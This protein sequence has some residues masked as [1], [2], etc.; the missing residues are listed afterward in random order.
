MPNPTTSRENKLAFEVVLAIFSYDEKKRD[1]KFATIE[2]EIGEH[3][4]P[5]R[6]VFND[7]GCYKTVDELI[8]EHIELDAINDKFNLKL[9]ACLDEPHR[10]PGNATHTASLIF[11]LDI[12]DQVNNH[13]LTWI[14]Y[15]KFFDMLENSEFGKDHDK[16]LEIAINHA[17]KKNR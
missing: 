12:S 7:V 3:E 14:E 15:D 13:E 5:S 8:Y 16:I 9:C 11:R 10:Y 6:R 1:F 4:L 2:N 17:N